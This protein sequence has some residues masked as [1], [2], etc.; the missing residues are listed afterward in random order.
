MVEQK[1]YVVKDVT[2]FNFIIVCYYYLILTQVKFKRS[3]IVRSVF[4]CQPSASHAV[5][6]KMGESLWVFVIVPCEL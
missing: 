6:V 1:L 3:F 5:F 2:V 4:A